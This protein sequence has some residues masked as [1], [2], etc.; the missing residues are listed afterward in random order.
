MGFYIMESIV[1]M[2]VLLIVIVS[3][4]VVLSLFIG[5]AMDRNDEQKEYDKVFNSV[6]TKKEEF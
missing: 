4:I 6:I 5:I 1:I 3:Q 2:Y